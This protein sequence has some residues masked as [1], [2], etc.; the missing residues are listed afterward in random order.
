VWRG[1]VMTDMFDPK[2]ATAYVNNVTYQN[3]VSFTDGFNS[4][5]WILGITLDDTDYLFG[6]KNSGTSP[7]SPHPNIGFIAAVTK[8]DY[9]GVGGPWI[10]PKLYS[11]YAW[12]CGVAGI[13]FG[14][15]VGRGY[16][17]SKYGTIAALNAAWGTSSFYTSFCDAGG[18]GVGTGVLDED[19]RHTAWMGHNAYTLVGT[20]AAVAAD[21]NQFVYAY[22][23][24]YASTAVAAIRTVDTHHLIFGPAALSAGGYEDRPQVLQAFSDAGINVFQMSASP[25]GDFS[26]HRAT[27]DL[28]GKPIYLWYAIS[29][30]ADSALY[31]YVQQQ[32]VPDYATQA[33]RGAGYTTDLN[34]FLAAQAT[35]GDNYMLGIDWWEHTDG[36]L[37]EKCNWGL[38][39]DRDNA[40]DGRED[41]NYQVRN[42]GGYLTVP[43]DR[44]YGDFITPV[45]ATNSS[46][47]QQLIYEWQH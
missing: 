45:T 41:V 44:S 22:A 4:T 28:I 3:T 7:V 5:P 15:G 8:F 37:V 34:S 23:Y 43:E 12:T 38:I 2:V 18:Y 39:S 11:K 16:L 10:D 33:L 29:A 21:M 30:N 1:S 46:I 20:N 42:S 9:T 35:N 40:Y 36:N 31:P 14:F 19:G 47:L 13:N 27:Y 24:K 25:T 26:G 32:G 17:D 6:L